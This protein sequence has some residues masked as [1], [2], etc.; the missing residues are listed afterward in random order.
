[1]LLST[2]VSKENQCILGMGGTEGRMVVYKRCSNMSDVPGFLPISCWAGWGYK[3]KGETGAKEANV[4]EG[5]ALLL[6][7]GWSWKGLGSLAPISLSWFVLVFICF[8]KQ[9][10][11]QG[12]KCELMH[13]LGF[14]FS[15]GDESADPLTVSSEVCFLFSSWFPGTPFVACYVGS[16]LKCTEMGSWLLYIEPSF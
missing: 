10:Q 16:G 2:S 15:L 13:N 12:K 5:Y 8:W 1:M 11:P 4:Q 9:R 14:Y 6:P 3:R 7:A